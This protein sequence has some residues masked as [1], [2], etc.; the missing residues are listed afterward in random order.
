MFSVAFATLEAC[1]ASRACC[2][3]AE[4]SSE[5]ATCAPRRWTVP[6]ADNDGD[7][8]SYRLATKYETTGSSSSGG[9]PT[10]MTA[11]DGLIQWQPTS[12][13]LYGSQVIVEDAYSSVAVDYILRVQDPQVSCS[14]MPR[15]AEAAPRRLPLRWP[16]AP[17]HEAA[18]A[19]PC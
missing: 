11:S 6:A 10:G 1:C 4:L 19:P 14:A 9:N 7:K 12:N 13:G 8:L 5:K 16:P 3:D 2:V 15:L 17:G 18:T